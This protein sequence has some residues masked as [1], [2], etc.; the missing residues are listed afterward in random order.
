MFPTKLV[1][2]IPKLVQYEKLYIYICVLMFAYH[3][4]VDNGTCLLTLLNR[5][6]SFM[7]GNLPQAQTPSCYMMQCENN[8]MLLQVLQKQHKF[9]GREMAAHKSV[10]YPIDTDLHLLCIAEFQTSRLLE[11]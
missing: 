4:N 8:I 2:L 9:Q 10:A 5:I 3:R 1:M 7:I 11:N 6:L